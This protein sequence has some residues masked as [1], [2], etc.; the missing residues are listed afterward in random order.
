MPKKKKI[1]NITLELSDKQ[2]QYLK[3]DGATPEG[4]GVTKAQYE[5]WEK[6]P[7]FDL[8]T[9]M[10]YA[11]MVEHNELEDE[12]ILREIKAAILVNFKYTYS[13]IE[14][15]LSL[16]P[17][18]LLQWTHSENEGTGDY[19]RIS[20]EQLE[21]QMRAVMQDRTPTDERDNDW[22]KQD[23][24]IPL[25]LAGKNN[26]EIADELGVSRQTVSEWRNYDDNFRETLRDEIKVY[27]DTQRT[28][29][30]QVLDKAYQSLETLLDSSDPQ[31][32][33]KAAVEILK[34]SNK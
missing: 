8:I 21:E 5:R 29:F 32:K 18:T 7:L 16:E 17:G 15:H 24:A 19:F 10:L 26:Q 4:L 3:S 23:L 30:A 1:S 13:A 27:R 22:K 6:E 20:Q 14:S 9:D 11:D 2:R 33:L 31:I 12:S 34:S 25:I 28:K